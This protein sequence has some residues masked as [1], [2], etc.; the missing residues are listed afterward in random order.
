MDACCH[1]HDL[2]YAAAGVTSD[3]PP[4]AGQVGMWTAQGFVR[5]IAADAT[6]VGCVTAT[7]F[8]SHWYG[9]EA[10]A[11]RAAVQ[12]IFGGRA[13][14]AAWLLTNGFTV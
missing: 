2:D 12:L 7:E 13:T 10:A 11:Y 6:L 4:P 14:I 5:T 3:D 9:P 8:D 1:R